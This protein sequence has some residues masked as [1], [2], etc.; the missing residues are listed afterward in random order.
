MAKADTNATKVYELIKKWTNFDGWN[1][2]VPASIGLYSTREA[3]EAMKSSM[4]VEDK[5]RGVKQNV[6]YYIA[7]REV[8]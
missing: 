1:I 2:S 6:W 3:A 5:E 7:E 4:E 8:Q